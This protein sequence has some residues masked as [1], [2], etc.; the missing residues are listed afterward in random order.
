MV[1]QR[2]LIVVL[3]PTASGKTSMAIDLAKYFDAEII[4]CDARQFYREMN[5]G[6]AKP[7]EAELGAVPHH[8]INN[9]SIFDE[10]SVG[11]YE[12]EV[13]AFLESYFRQKKIAVMV[14]GSGLFAR[15]VCEGVDRYPDIPAH[16][17]A[18]LQTLL[19]ENGIEA[20]QTEL[21][22]RDP[23]YYE[24]VDLQNPHRLIRALEVCRATGKPF[25][26][27]QG[28]A[29][30][31]RPFRSIKIAIDWERA[32]LYDRINQRVDLMMEAGLEQEARALFPHRE[33][34]ALQTVG[35]REL[36]DY[37]EGKTSKENAVALIKQNT[38]RYA[39]RQLTWLRKEAEVHW[40]ATGTALSPIVKYIE[41]QIES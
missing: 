20:L 7:N 29:K 38:R 12:Q 11:D 2:T 39:K 1:K 21:K 31:E 5:I 18:E 37:F 28:Q 36:F 15:I 26:G 30:A 3:G 10:Y 32:A 8:F 33:L 24:R 22:L 17:R 25:S 35:Y 41:T 4:S 14:G 19:E 40:V 16:I 27:F 23:D 34:N 6:T 13:L 9:L